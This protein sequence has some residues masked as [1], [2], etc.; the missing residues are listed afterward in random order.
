MRLRRPQ[1]PAM[2]IKVR[3]LTMRAA[4]IISCAIAAG[5]VVEAHVTVLPRESQAGVVERYTVR[6]P[7]E[8]QVT[9]TSVELEVPAGVTVIEVVAGASYTFDTRREDDRIVAITWKQEIP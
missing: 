2:F 8:G 6:V 1:P 9:T 7:T 5:A 3:T 4:I